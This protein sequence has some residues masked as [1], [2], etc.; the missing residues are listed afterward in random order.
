MPP[1]TRDFHTRWP[2]VFD[3][4]F[5][6]RVRVFERSSTVE[7]GLASQVVKMSLGL[8]ATGGRTTPGCFRSPFACPSL[9]RFGREIAL[10]L[11]R[12]PFFRRCNSIVNSAT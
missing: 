8:S 10:A 9:S 7:T 6:E 2:D 3:G 11:G 4:V 12:T 5:V 1:I